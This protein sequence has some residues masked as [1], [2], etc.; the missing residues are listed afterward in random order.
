MKHRSLIGT[1][2]ALALLA[3]TGMPH[4]QAVTFT[5]PAGRSAPSQATG[6]ASR[7][8]FIPGSTNR[9]PKQAT[10]GASRGIFTPGAGNRTPKQATG[11]ASRGIFTPGAGNRTPKQATGGAARGVFTP[12][13]GN[14]APK[15]AAGGASRVGSYGLDAANL[16]GASGSSALTALLPQNFYG[17]TLAERPTIL[18]YLPASTATEA[19]FSL[20]DEAGN[21]LHQMTLPVPEAAGIMAI[22]LPVDVP[23]LM[24]GQN[25]QWFLALKVDGRLNPSTPYVDGWIQ[26]ID[27]SAELATALQQPDRLKQATALGKHGVWYD[28]VAQLATLRAAKGDAHAKDW[29]ELLESVGLKEIAQAPLLVAAN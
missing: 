22:Q 11:G 28:C 14:S 4:A 15:Q 5:P 12:N 25:Y 7:G 23:A 9:A 26:R 1:L 17:T 16:V 24:V 10:G 29:V 20:K 27:A 19:V 3:S 13:A 21:T 18:V 6:G 2:G 8:M